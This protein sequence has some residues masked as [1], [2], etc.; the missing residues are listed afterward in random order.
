MLNL[1]FNGGQRIAHEYVWVAK[2]QFSRPN[3]IYKSPFQ[4][5]L[6]I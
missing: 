5:C 2:N 6:E 3:F 4:S 1:Q